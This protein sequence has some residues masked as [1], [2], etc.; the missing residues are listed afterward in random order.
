[1]VLEAASML[2]VDPFGKL[3]ASL[4][5]RLSLRKGDGRRKAFVGDCKGID[6]AER[7]L[8]HR[9]AEFIDH[10]A[11]RPCLGLVDIIILQKPAHILFEQPQRKEVSKWSQCVF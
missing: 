2:L 5:R 9:G 1:M 10:I 6:I 4:G 3:R 7:F 11:N 8:T